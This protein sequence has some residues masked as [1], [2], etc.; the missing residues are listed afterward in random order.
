MRQLD[1][2]FSRAGPTTVL[3]RRIHR[4]PFH[5]GRVFPGV[6]ADSAAELILQNASGALL[7]G[8][9]VS[10]GLTVRPG[11]AITVRG[12]GAVSVTGVPGGGR[13]CEVT[14]LRVDEGGTA[15]LDPGMRVT[16]PHARHR[17][18]TYVGVAP[19]ATA[20]IVDATAV[21]P[22]CTPDTAG[23]IDTAIVVRRLDARD[24]CVID[25][26][27]VPTPPPSTSL[28][29][30][31]TVVVACPNDA[32]DDMLAV[33]APCERNAEVY[34]AVSVLPNRLGVIVRIAG[35]HGGVVRTALTRA[36]TDAIAVVSA[37]PVTTPAHGLTPVR[38]RS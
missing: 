17:Q 14:T 31:G 16:F 29:S 15:L 26:Q 28:T 3:S 6:G 5:I 30:F 38:A 13:A 11:A 33:L 8:D 20:V 27:F 35:R 24:R 36:S 2:E 7:P 22:E 25:R 34:G 19:T 21:H 10:V 32:V 12:Q 9:R 18:R 1:L 37:R 4:W 23:S